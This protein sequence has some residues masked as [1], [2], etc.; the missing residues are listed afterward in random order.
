MTESEDFERLAERLE[1]IAED[2]D[3]LI[4]DRLRTAVALAADGTEPDPEVLKEER[5]IAR[6]RRAVTKAAA[7]L[8]P[9][10]VD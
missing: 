1:A 3:D 2:L 6:A 8:R 10:P 9:A 7:I 4:T 5:R